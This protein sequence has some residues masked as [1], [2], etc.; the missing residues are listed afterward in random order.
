MNTQNRTE[1]TEIDVLEHSP[2][3]RPVIDEVMEGLRAETPYFPPKLHYD[4]RGSELFEEICTL[5]EYYLT[6]TELSIMREHAAS[7]ASALGERCVLIEPGSGAS[8]KTRLLL[9]ALHDPAAYVPVEISRDFLVDVAERIAS[10]FEDLE[11]LPVWA[12][13]TRSHP[14]PKATAD[15]AADAGPGRRAVY[16]PGS[17]IGNFPRDAAEDLLGK[18]AKM[19]GPGGSV[20][21]GVDL[22]KD[23]ARMEAAYNDDRGVTDAFNKNMLT[24]INALTGSDFDEDLWTF[25]AAWDEAVGAI[26]SH[27]TATDDHDVSI[28]GEVFSFRRGDRVQT[29]QSHKYRRGDFRALAG[30]AGLD[31]AGA[32]TDAAGDF[33]VVHLVAR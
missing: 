9:S 18:F 21:V 27:V 22:E 5:D 29:E 11:V 8:T 19:V 16:F 1:P 20:V 12:D 13:F 15:D 24:N 4:Q 17:T 25:R 7:I 2:E 6:R 26:V 33:A 14:V 3:Q 32:W 23:V 31:E 10:D 28:G 30:R